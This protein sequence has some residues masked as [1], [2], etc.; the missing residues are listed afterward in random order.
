MFMPDDLILWLHNSQQQQNVANGTAN[1]IP[2][3]IALRMAQEIA[4]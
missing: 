1:G 2:I 4:C 3:D